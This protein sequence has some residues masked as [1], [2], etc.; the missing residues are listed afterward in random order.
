M[1]AMENESLPGRILRHYYHNI[2]YY[3][4]RNVQKSD[5]NIYK[6]IYKRISANRVEMYFWLEMNLQILFHE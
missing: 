5:T 4:I 3:Y 1:S 6:Y 2:K